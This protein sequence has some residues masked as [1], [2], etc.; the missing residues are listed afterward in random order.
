MLIGSR[1]YAVVLPALL[2]LAATG[3]QACSVPVFY[4]AMGRWPPSKH[5]IESPGT[6][7][8]VAEDPRLDHCNATL[9]GGGGERLR[10]FFPGLAKPWWD[11]VSTPDTVGARLALLIDSPKRTELVR[12]LAGGESAVWV[13]V[14]SGD[15][16]KDDAVEVM[17]SAR[18]RL[19][20]TVAK[21]P[22]KDAK[23]Q[24]AGASDE[25]PDLAV[26]PR[27]AFSVLRLD[28]LD[29]AEA[30]FNA[31]ILAICDNPA[32]R[33]LPI[34]VPVFGRGRALLALC[35]ADLTEAKID[36]ACMFLVGSCSCEVK[37]LNAGVD[38]LLHADWDRLVSKPGMMT[39]APAPK[40]A[41]TATD[42]R[43]RP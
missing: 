8:V 31:Q 36:E 10:A 11:E 33:S 9:V 7:G 4:Y 41:P 14:S 38:L 2:L 43:N 40:T 23:A 13:L 26:P 35:G 34:A 22:E 16:A 19:I 28:H 20:E 17:V 39:T 1:L 24:G 32:A 3:A 27:L 15:T 21:L 6:A 29:P 37:D 18:L 30:G 42:N 5:R 12:R 25:M